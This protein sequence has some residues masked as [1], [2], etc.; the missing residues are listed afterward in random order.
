MFQLITG[1]SGSGK[2]AYA[3]K[4]VLKSDTD[5]RVY[6]ATMNPS[7]REGQARVARHRKLRADKQFETIERYTGLKKLS[8]PKNSVVLLESISNLVANELFDP[9]GAHENTVREVSLGID[10]LLAQTKDLIVVTDEVFSDGISFEAET[11]NY[12][13]VMGEVNCFLSARAARV[14]ELVYGIPVL[15]KDSGEK[16]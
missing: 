1:G 16:K 12:L 2:S 5:P 6:L 13:S 15:L 10:A 8:V 7:G 4:Q 3:E 11:E 14:T 9:D